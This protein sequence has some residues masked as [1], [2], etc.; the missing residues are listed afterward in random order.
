MTDNYLPFKT[1]E[2]INRKNKIKNGRMLFI[3]EHENDCFWFLR[4]ALPVKKESRR[5]IVNKKSKLIEH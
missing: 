4:R 3:L 1:V 2:K 5:L